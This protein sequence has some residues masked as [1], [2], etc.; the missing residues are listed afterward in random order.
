MHILWSDGVDN[1]SQSDVRISTTIHFSRIFK[2][3][4][5]SEGML[6]VCYIVLSCNHLSTNSKN[7]A[8]VLQHSNSRTII[9]NFFLFLL[10]RCCASPLWF[11]ICVPGLSAVCWQQIQFQHSCPN[12]WV[13]ICVW[14]TLVHVCNWGPFLLHVLQSTIAR[15]IRN[16][17][18][19]CYFCE[20]DTCWSLIYVSESWKKLSAAPQTPQRSHSWSRLSA[21]C[22]TAHSPRSSPPHCCLQGPHIVRK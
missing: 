1:Q 2:A 10:V 5:S 9:Y 13:L 6:V 11:H 22:S 17:Q 7:S 21:S 19:K 3:K 18:S 16:I 14:K 15:A 20:L 12:W 4:N 8:A